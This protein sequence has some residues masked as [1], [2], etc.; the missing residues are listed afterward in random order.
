[1]CWWT[2]RD[3]D[4]KQPNRCRRKTHFIKP[5]IVVLSSR[6]DP[7]DDPKQCPTI[8]CSIYQI[9][10]TICELAN[11]KNSTWIFI[12]SYIGMDVLGRVQYIHI[13]FLVPVVTKIW[14]D[15]CHD[16]LNWGT[17]HWVTFWLRMILMG[18]YAGH[19]LRWPLAGVE[20]WAPAAAED[21]EEYNL[22]RW[23]TLRSITCCSWRRKSPTGY[24]L[25]T[26]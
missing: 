6:L 15:T 22:L 4:V 24:G 8:T 19:Q 3:F 7:I 13:L 26:I 5:S 23:K 16:W 10:N 20:P 17:T 1:M 11:M 21:S 14:L 12:L 9:A 2:S 25:R 18:W